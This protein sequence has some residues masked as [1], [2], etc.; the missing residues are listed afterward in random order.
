MG[1]WLTKLTDMA[2]AEIVLKG[3]SE[4]VDVWQR[5]VGTEYIFLL[6]IKQG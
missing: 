6:E 5:G 3:D 4:L 1:L 2:G